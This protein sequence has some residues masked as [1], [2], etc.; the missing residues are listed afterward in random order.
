MLQAKQGQ[1]EV[2]GTEL[3]L[4]ETLVLRG[5]KLAVRTPACCKLCCLPQDEESQQLY[6][7]CA[8]A[9]GSLAV[10]HP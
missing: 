3:S 9:G 1:A 5:Q 10:K 7:C 2:F 4:G 6:L 8:L